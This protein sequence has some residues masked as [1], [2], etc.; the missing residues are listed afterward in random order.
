MKGKNFSRVDRGQCKASDFYQTPYSLTRALL[1]AEEFDFQK[2]VYE[3]AAGRGA[4]V[5]VLE[6]AWGNGLVEYGDI[7]TGRDFMMRGMTVPY[8]IT[9]PP[10]S[11][12]LEFVLKA[13]QVAR[14]K[15]AMLLPV[16]YLHGQERFQRLWQDRVYPLAKVHVL[17]RYPLL[18]NTIRSDGKF[19][20][21]MMA[22]AWYVFE[23]QWADK[24]EIRWMDVQP[25]VLKS[26]LHVKTVDQQLEMEL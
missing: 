2:T 23:K 25:F 22:F 26:S 17:T 14:E 1:E 5:K 19:Q 6:A 20:T 11:L 21:G 13:K 4:I 3:P 10:F 8:I 12:A 16:S 18:T 9:N 15:F 24:P 7:Q